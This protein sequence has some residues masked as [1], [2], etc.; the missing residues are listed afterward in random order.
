MKYSVLVN[1]DNKIKDNYLDKINLVEIEDVDKK[2]VYLEEKTYESY[3][4]LKKYLEKLNI[5][6]GI[7]SAYRTI[8]Y[9]E[10]L[11]NEILEE[12]GLDYTKTHVAEPSF[13]E[14]HTGLAIDIGVLVNGEYTDEDNL[15]I[16]EEIHKHL[17]KFGFITLS[18]FPFIPLCDTPFV[19]PL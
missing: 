7:T 17:Y 11:Y 8:E 5:N 13:S 2:K 15:E 9:Q 6:I 4:E 1:R 18:I 19:T 16:F 14:H 10:K 3:L 12:K